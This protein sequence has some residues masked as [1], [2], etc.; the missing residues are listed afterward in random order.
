[1]QTGEGEITEKKLASVFEYLG[2]NRSYLDYLGLLS[3]R[4][5][6]TVRE[7]GYFLRKLGL[8]L[9]RKDYRLR[10]QKEARYH[11]GR[12]VKKNELGFI[13]APGFDFMKSLCDN[14][15]RS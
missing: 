3:K 11:I 15:N 10:T 4:A 2:P 12:D 13:T 14:T 1:M 7:V 6:P 9:V 8:Y 5:T